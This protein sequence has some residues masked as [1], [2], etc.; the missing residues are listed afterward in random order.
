MLIQSHLQHMALLFSLGSSLQT[1]Y[2]SL[3]LLQQCHIPF[4][5]PSSHRGPLGALLAPVTQAEQTK[6]DCKTDGS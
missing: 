3:F 4:L 6:L 5:L 2:T 1:D